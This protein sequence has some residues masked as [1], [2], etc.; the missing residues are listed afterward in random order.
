MQASKYLI[1]CT[2]WQNYK[3]IYLS[4]EHVLYRLFVSWFVIRMFHTL[5]KNFH[6]FLEVVELVTISS[7]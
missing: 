3:Y 7:R 4:Q 6:K 2:S 1:N 5:Q